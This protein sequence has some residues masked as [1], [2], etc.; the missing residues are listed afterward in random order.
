MEVAVNENYSNYT[1][2]T[3][4]KLVLRA[5]EI[6]PYNR[7]SEKLNNINTKGIKVPLDI[8]IYDVR[9][10]AIILANKSKN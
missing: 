9:C 1:S 6:L 3:S 10:N 5:Y 7:K 4:I 2:E 8:K